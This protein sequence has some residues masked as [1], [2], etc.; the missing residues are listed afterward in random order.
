ME[1]KDE[2]DLVFFMGQV[3]KSLLSELMIVKN[4]LGNSHPA[5]LQDFRSWEAYYFLW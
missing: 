3:V 1:Q 4:Y 5:A 2:S